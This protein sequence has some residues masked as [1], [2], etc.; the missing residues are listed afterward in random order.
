M[1]RAFDPQW[2]WLFTITGNQLKGIVRPQQFARR[3][4]LSGFSSQASLFNHVHFVHDQA[5]SS[6]TTRT[7]AA[8]ARPVLATY[9]ARSPSAVNAVMTFGASTRTRTTY[10]RSNPCLLNRRV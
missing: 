2:R 3:D 10:D 4:D 9:G 8:S 5:G 1:I 7:I 6:V